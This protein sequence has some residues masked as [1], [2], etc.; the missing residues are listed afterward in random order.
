LNVPFSRPALEE[1]GRLPHF[2]IAHA[3]EFARF[4]MLGTLNANA[5]LL[6][7]NA[8]AHTSANWSAMS[9]ASLFVASRL[10]PT[11]GPPK[12]P[13]IHSMLTDR[14]NFYKPDGYDGSAIDNQTASAFISTPSTTLTW[15]G[16]IMKRFIVAALVGLTIAA[17]FSTPASAFR[18]LA[19]SSNGVNTWG[20]GIVFSRAARFA[21]R[22][23]RVAGGVD[24]R[25]AYCR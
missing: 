23:C 10:W 5:A 18:C 24:C 17:S 15:K 11:T 3:L 2:L 22:H 1:F 16:P 12:K 19:T 25:I 6:K 20:Y 9:V 13:P 7:K 8:A 14:Q 4:A 21:V